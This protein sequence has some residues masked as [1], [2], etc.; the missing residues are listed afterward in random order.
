MEPR[1]R[2]LSDVDAYVNVNGPIVGP[3]SL[4]S[5]RALADAESRIQIDKWHDRERA[6]NLAKRESQH[7]AEEMALARRGVEAAEAQ[8]RSADEA[9]K[10]AK[11]AKVQSWVAVGIAAGAALISLVQIFVK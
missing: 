4:N 2:S 10:I 8:A 7:R 3:L 1:F 5:A 9:V 6:A 11:A